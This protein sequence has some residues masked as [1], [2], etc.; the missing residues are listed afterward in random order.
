[1]PSASGSAWFV[2][3]HHQNIF[4]VAKE[5]F[6]L[7]QFGGDLSSVITAS[8]NKNI[9]F[10]TAFHLT[11]QVLLVLLDTKSETQWLSHKDRIVLPEKSWE[12]LEHWLNTQ[13]EFNPDQLFVVCADP[14]IFPHSNVSK[15]EI[16]KLVN[17][18]LTF[19]KNTGSHVTVL[20]GNVHVGA[21][22]TVTDTTNN[23]VVMQQL[24][25]SGISAKPPSKTALLI[26]EK[27]NRISFNLSDTL[28]L[29]MEKLPNG[30]MF[31]A[32]QNFLCLLPYVASQTHHHH[33]IHSD[34]QHHHDHQ[35]A[36]PCYIASWIGVPFHHSPLLSPL[37][38]PLTLKM[39]VD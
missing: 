19:S 33:H 23:R 7:F 28:R 18:F 32:T 3:L 35:K 25:S 36:R 22:G 8:P 9:P 13:T 29:Q 5:F 14:I 16:E 15:R 26:E 39:A 24:I 6:L 34:H 38:Q 31:L 20:A 1:M 17:C 21:Y 10:T 37:P 2:H 27:L 12:E 30:D 4:S 11:G